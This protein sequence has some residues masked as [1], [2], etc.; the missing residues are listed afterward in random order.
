MRPRLTLVALL[1]VSA[2]S[3]AACGPKTTPVTVKPATP[4]VASPSAKVDGT[5]AEGAPT[6]LV[7]YPGAR[8]ETSGVVAFPGKRSYSAVLVTKD[9]FTKTLDGM[10]AGL[11]KAGWQVEKTDI[12]TAKQKS[13]ML[14]ITNATTAG[15]VTLTEASG[16]VRI[17]TVIDIPQK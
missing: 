8:V 5:L 9:A 14:T 1:I 7:L 11:E 4:D 16:S 17:E 2:F 13:T 15:L 3:L 10:A 12:G 6:D